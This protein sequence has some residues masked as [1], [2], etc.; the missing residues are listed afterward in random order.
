MTDLPN[1]ARL[2]EQRIGFLAAK[3][4]NHQRSPPPTWM[5][6]DAC[7]CL[8]ALFLIWLISSCAG[9]RVR[10]STGMALASLMGG[11]W[12]K[13]FLEHHCPRVA[14]RAKLK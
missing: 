12:C 1:V 6:L 3:L 4:A 13:L 5:I 14:Q 8:A 10:G 9:A 11:T 7:N 2:A